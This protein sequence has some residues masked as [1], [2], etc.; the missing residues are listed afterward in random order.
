MTYSLVHKDLGI[1][2]CVCRINVNMAFILDVY[3]KADL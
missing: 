2:I 3:I 1:L